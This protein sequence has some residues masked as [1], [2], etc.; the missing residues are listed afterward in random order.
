MKFVDKATI[1]EPCDND[2]LAQI[3]SSENIYHRIV[4][5]MKQSTQEYYNMRMLLGM[6]CA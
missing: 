3:M 2:I 5:I 4:Y 6:K 1:L